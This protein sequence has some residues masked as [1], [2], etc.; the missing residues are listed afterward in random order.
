MLDRCQRVYD[1]LRFTEFLSHAVV[2]KPTVDNYSLEYYDA[3]V[4]SETSKI[5]F[6]DDFDELPALDCMRS[7]VDPSASAIP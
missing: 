6:A 1:R 7:G 3:G 2:S 5:L 4:T